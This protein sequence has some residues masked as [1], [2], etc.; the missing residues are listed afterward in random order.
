MTPPKDK[1][2][3]CRF[4]KKQNESYIKVK[5]L[6]HNDT[7]HRHWHR[8][9][10]KACSSNPYFLIWALTPFSLHLHTSVVFC[11]YGNYYNIKKVTYMTVIVCVC[12]IVPN[13]TKFYSFTISS[14]SLQ[15]ISIACRKTYLGS[16]LSVLCSVWQFLNLFLSAA[17][18]IILDILFLTFIIAS[19][20]VMWVS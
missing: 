17:C 4:S 20:W 12:D 11:V 10:S 2:L 8:F 7:V 13:R 1:K 19:N 15:Y 9:V 5:L 18:F 6:F 16:S 14:W 3:I